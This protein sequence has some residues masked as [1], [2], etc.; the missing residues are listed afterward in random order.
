MGFL[1]SLNYPS[2][3]PGLRHTLT[4]ARLSPY[5]RR[6]S[7]RCT[8][9]AVVHPG[10]LGATVLG[11][12]EHLDV[13]VGVSGTLQRKSPEY[14][15]HVGPAGPHAGPALSPV[16]GCDAGFIP[17]SRTRTLRHG[18]VQHL[19]M[20]GLCVSTGCAPPH[21]PP[22]IAS[23]PGDGDLS[24]ERGPAHLWEVVGGLGEISQ[25]PTSLCTERCSPAAPRPWSPKLAALSRSYISFQK[26]KMCFFWMK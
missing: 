16:P 21:R 20:L 17:T 3:V 5:V 13:G 18:G 11:G 14:P 23:G 10:A 22:T 2:G 8:E 9:R 26:T 1:L 24:E 4:C 7:V 15:L 19:G 6:K 12:A 25:G